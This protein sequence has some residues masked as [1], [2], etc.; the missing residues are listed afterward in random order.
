MRDELDWSHSKI[1]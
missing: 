1:F